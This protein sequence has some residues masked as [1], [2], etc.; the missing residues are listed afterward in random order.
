MLTLG[1]PFVCL[2]LYFNS[3]FWKTTALGAGIV[4]LFYL[5]Y[6]LLFGMYRMYGHPSRH[7]I[8]RLIRESGLTD[9]AVVA[10][11]HIGTYRH[12]YILADLLPSAVIHS[13]DCWDVRGEPKE[14]AIRDVRDLETPPLHHPR[15]HPASAKDSTLALP[16]G[17]CDAVVFGFG[18][19]EIPYGARAKLFAETK[20]VLKPGGKVLMFEHGIDFHNVII[21]GPSIG[22]VVPRHEWA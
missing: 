15:I 19:H 11:L 5:G 12:S 8:E 16:D 4:S 6:S 10:D 17:S 18:T 13:I 22:H 2:G 3:P 7:Y 14:I 1:I 20:R 21:F 9:P